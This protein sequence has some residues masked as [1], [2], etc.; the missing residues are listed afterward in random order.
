MNLQTFLL[1]SK[2][3]DLRQLL[4]TASPQTNIHTATTVSDGLL[5]W[6]KISPAL[7]ICEGDPHTLAPLLEYARQ[8]Q[9]PRPSL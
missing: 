6:S 5:L 8:A 9:N 2:D 4:Q 1:I 3:S 7:V